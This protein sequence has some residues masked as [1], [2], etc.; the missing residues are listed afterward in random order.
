MKEEDVQVRII[1]FLFATAVVLCVWGTS[2]GN[3][4]LQGVGGDHALSS[5][6]DRFYSYADKDFHAEAYDFSGVGRG[7]AWLTM[8]SPRYFVSAAH[9]DPAYGA[10]AT[11]YEDNTTSSGRHQYTVDSWG[12]QTKYEVGGLY[13]DLWLGRLTE[14]IPEADN[15]A[16]YPV[17]D[18]D[19]ESDYIGREIYAYGTPNRVGRNNL[20][21]IYDSSSSGKEGRTMA[22]DFDA[23][24]GSGMGESECYMMTGD[25]GGPSFIVWNGELALVGIHWWN[26][27][28][29]PY[30]GARSG[31]SFVPYYIDQLNANMAFGQSVTTVPEPACMTLL[32]LGGL[33]TI[34]RRRR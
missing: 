17:L 2:L 15:I 24:E 10:T 14:D 32:V 30:N 8:I 22:F 28:S 6:H 12:F 20:D 34:V 1:R 3:T 26:N 5:T 19:S 31:D 16:Y 33:M 18:L 11:F 21:W 7:G 9:A 13:S 29:T 27:G 25:S 23:T 4:Y